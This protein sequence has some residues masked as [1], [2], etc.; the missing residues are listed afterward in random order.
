MNA[1]ERFAIG[2]YLGEVPKGKTFDEV[3]HMVLN[4]DDDVYVREDYEHHSRRDVVWLI[5]ALCEEL[6]KYFIPREESK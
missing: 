2:E 5:G 4:Q 3:M 1:Y 6:E